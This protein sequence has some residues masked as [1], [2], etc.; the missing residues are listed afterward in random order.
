M[1]FAIPRWPA[2]SCCPWITQPRTAVGTTHRCLWLIIRN[3]LLFFITHSL[4]KFLSPALWLFSVYFH[5]VVAWKITDCLDWWLPWIFS[6]IPGL[7]PSVILKSAAKC[8]YVLNS[9]T[10]AV[11]YFI[12]QSCT[13]NH[14][15]AT[16]CIKSFFCIVVLRTLQLVTTVTFLP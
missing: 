15:L 13:R 1:F 12:P 11:L 5:P 6:M 14:H 4:Q 10:G 3:N 9:L 16:R 2:L 8:I 7:S